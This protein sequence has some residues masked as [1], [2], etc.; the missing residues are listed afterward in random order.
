M[1]KNK[2][3]FTPF[4]ISIWM[5]LAVT[6]ILG[7]IAGGA[8]SHIHLLNG[9][10]EKTEKRSMVDPVECTLHHYTFNSG[11]SKL[12]EEL[13]KL[14]KNELGNIKRSMPTRS[15]YFESLFRD[16]TGDSN[17]LY[18]LKVFRKGKQP[19]PTVE[20]NLQKKLDSL[21]T[22]VWKD[23]LKNSIKA[24]IT[25]MPDFIEKAVARQQYEH[26]D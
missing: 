20:V 15:I 12:V 26:L 21:S 8:V 14:H 2:K 13:I 25:L 19:Q 22:Q 24:Q 6:F 3:R 5:T 16:T 1:K 18:L 10:F 17:T 7:A 4:D 9:T 23:H 11:D